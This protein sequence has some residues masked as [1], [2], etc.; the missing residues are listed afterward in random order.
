MVNRPHPKP[1]NFQ[2]GGFDLLSLHGARSG[3]RLVPKLAKPA[4]T[5]LASLGGGFGTSIYSIN[6]C[7]IGQTGIVIFINIKSFTL[8]DRVSTLTLPHHES[9]IRTVATTHQQP[10]PK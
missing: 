2:S 6:N 8:G 9:Y 3:D 5:V 4:A 10:R 7:N 1:Q